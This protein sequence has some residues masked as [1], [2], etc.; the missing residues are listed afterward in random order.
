M[1][2]CMCPHIIS[3]KQLPFC[4]KIFP[5]ITCFLAQERDNLSVICST[6]SHVPPKQ[7]IPCRLNNVYPSSSYMASCLI[8]T[9]KRGLQ[10]LNL[11]TRSNFHLHSAT[12]LRRLCRLH[13]STGGVSVHFLCALVPFSVS[14][15]TLRA[16]Y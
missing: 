16:A 8:H 4:N 10:L 13:V 5:F 11:T 9:S 14:V 1:F 6:K 2:K 15:K 7:T 3:S 12:N